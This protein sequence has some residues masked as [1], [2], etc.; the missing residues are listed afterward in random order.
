MIAKEIVSNEILPLSLKDNCAQAM[1]MMSIYRIKDLPV[2]EDDKLIGM[3]SEE[4]VSTTDPE[5]LIEQTHISKSY[6]YVQEGDH[7]FEIL[8]RLAQNNMTVVPV[9][10]EDEAFIGIISQED[11]IKYYARTY[12]FTEPG[13]IIVIETTKRGYSLSEISRIVELENGR[14]ISSFIT[15]SET[16]ENVLLTI[17]INQ[18][19]VSNIISALERYDYKISATFVEDEYADDLKD[20][21]DMLM[22]YLNI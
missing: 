3:V 15:S 9:V 18:Q 22:N 4:T 2:V 8:N 1:T 16:S 12:S 5:T 6:V 7:V 17:K 20:R 19:E 11:I 14:I 21:Y 10:D 13:S